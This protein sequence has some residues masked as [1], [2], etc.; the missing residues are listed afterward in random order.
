VRLA[1][2][3][4]CA[5]G[6][7]AT[8]T[9][10]AN[11]PPIASGVAFC[12]ALKAR[13]PTEAAAV[14]HAALTP[15]ALDSNDAT[16]PLAAWLRTQPCVISVEPAA[17]VL[18]SEPAVREIAIVAN[19]GDAQNYRCPAALRMAPGAKFTLGACEILVDI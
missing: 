4:L 7:G 6:G 15:E 16:E 14:A 9:P 12:D 1:V 8:Q 2:L 17:S 5:C 13:H 11:R 10:P 18:D 3:A 19:L